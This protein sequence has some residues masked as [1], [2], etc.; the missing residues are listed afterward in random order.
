M[1][2]ISYK[3]LLTLENLGLFDT[4]IFKTQVS[5]DNSNDYYQIWSLSSESVL[6]LKKIERI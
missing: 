1:D 5:L 6:Y 4:S 2:E 3:E